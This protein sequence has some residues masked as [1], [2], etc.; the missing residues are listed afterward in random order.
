MFENYFLE[1][2]HFLTDQLNLAVN[3]TVALLPNMIT[4]FKRFIQYGNAFQIYFKF[5]LDLNWLKTD[6]I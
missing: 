5:D 1:V 6:K 4:S 3:K 2:N